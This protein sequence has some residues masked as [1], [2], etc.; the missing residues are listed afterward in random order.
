MPIKRNLAF[1]VSVAILFHLSG[2]ASSAGCD[3]RATNYPACTRCPDGHM[4]ADYGADEKRECVPAGFP[5][6]EQRQRDP[7]LQ[8][9]MTP[10][11]PPVGAGVPTPTP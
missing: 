8:P 9:L 4:L 10:V 1:L 3:N 11:G 5:A 7:K 6:K 2:C